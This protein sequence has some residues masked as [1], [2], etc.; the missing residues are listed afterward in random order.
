MLRIG[1]T[2]GVGSGKSAAAAFFASLGAPIIDAD[3]IARDVTSK[4]SPV[5]A[6]IAETFGPEAL[7]PTGDLDRRAMRKRVFGDENAR[8]ALEAIVHPEVRRSIE[9]R[10]RTLPPT[11]YC[12]VVVPLLLE[13]GME[14]MFDHVVVVDCDEEIQVRRVAARDRTSATDARAILASQLSRQ[15]RLAGADDILENSGDL[16][17]LR[18]Q[19]E[20][21]HGE[22]SQTTCRD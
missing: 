18:T 13:T 15:E 5:L 21:L 9:K 10:I 17:H 7:T 12:V 6:Q 1:L 3:V 20:R 22:F 8:R 4:G 2:G 11:D 19:I 16:S 14:S